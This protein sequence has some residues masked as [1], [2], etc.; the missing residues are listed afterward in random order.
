MTILPSKKRSDLALVTGGNGFIGRSLIR[1]LNEN[2][3]RV[4]ALSS[5]P[6][7]KLKGLGI[8][9]SDWLTGDIFDAKALSLACDGVTVIFHLANTAH[10]NNSNKSDFY[11]VNV[12]A[13]KLLKR[14]AIDAR[15]SRLIYFSSILAADPKASAYAQ[16]KRDAEKLLLTHNDEKS[17]IKLH[18]TILRPANV[19]GRGMKGNLA[20]LITYIKSGNIPPLPTLHNRLPLISVQDVNAAALLAARGSHP[21][22]GVYVLTDSETYTPNRIESA[23][24]GALR[25]KR[26]M[27][28]TPLMLF[29]AGSL[30]AEIANRLGLWSNNF[31]LHTYR[32][33][34]TDKSENS[35]KAI[36][37]LGFCP[38]TTFET[39]LCD[40][41]GDSEVGRSD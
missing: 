38:T 27:W 28:S 18:T 26:P 7:P 16:S 20:S 32:A 13:T 21:S 10:I 34:I 24:Y 4:R 6:Y 8:A 41:I 25:K 12:H 31:G 19:Y 40:F 17:C 23:I 1:A 35:E 22:G 11:D 14:A 39:E 5:S 15:V 9:P 37:E 33:L 29:F 30:L 3:Y 2:G 36:A